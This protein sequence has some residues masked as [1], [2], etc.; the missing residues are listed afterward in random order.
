MG[1]QKSPAAFILAEAMAHYAQGNRV[2]LVTKTASGA[3][4]AFGVEGTVTENLSLLSPEPFIN[5]IG[6]RAVQQ[7]GGAFW[8]SDQKMTV[9]R[10]SMTEDQ[11]RQEDLEFDVNGDRYRV[12]AFAPTGMAWEFVIR[13]ET[14][15]AA[16]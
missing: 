14:P 6:G 3:N 5:G 1:I 4:A 12:L 7:S 13:R 10:E 9:S 11:A 2:S 16:P 8:W 15:D